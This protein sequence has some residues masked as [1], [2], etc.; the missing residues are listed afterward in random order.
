[1][2]ELSVVMP[3]MDEE[4]T[5]KICIQKARSVFDQYGLEGEI[6]VVDNSSDRTAEIASSMGAKVI[7]SVKGYGKAYLTGLSQAKGDYIAIADADNTYDLLELPKFLDPLMRG[8]ADFVIGS[9][10]KG[11]IKKGAMPWLHQH[12]GNP[13]LTWLLKRLFNIPISDAHC[14]MRAFT[15]DALGKMNIKSH[16]MEMASEMIIEAADKGLKIK[17]VPITYYVR[18]APSKLRSFQDGWRHIRFMMLYRPVPFLVAPGVFVFLLGMLL[19][20]TI[21]LK[22]NIEENRMHSLILGSMLLLIG[23]QT[24]TTGIYMKAYGFVHGMYKSDSGFIKKLLDYHSLERDLVTG[25]LLVVTGIF[26]G[27]RVI[28]TWVQ[29]GYGPMLEIGNAVMAMLFGAIGLQI[30]FT[31]IFLSVLMLDVDTDW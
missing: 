24:I 17:E 21:M 11:T 9:R 20:A 26:I 5:I 8:D 2:P 30:I 1:M 13:F 27:F 23:S 16:G 4:Q 6:I 10:L 3:S 22:E 29:S 18:D 14:G 15:K 7:R 25:A 12:I 28:S 19:T 31:S